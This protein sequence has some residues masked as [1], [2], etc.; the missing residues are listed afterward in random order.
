MNSEFPPIPLPQPRL[1]HR[2]RERSP[3]PKLEPA[4]IQIRREISDRLRQ[5]IE[6][7]DRAVRH[8]SPEQKR[9]IFLKLTHDRPLTKLDLQGTGLK[10]ISSPGE[11]ETLV[12][13]KAGDLGKLDKRIE[14]FG[15]N[16]NAEKVPKGQSLALKLINIAQ[17]KPIDRLS[18]ELVANYRKL[19]REP[20]LVYEIEISSF[21]SRESSQRADI[22]SILGEL[23]QFLGVADGRIYDVDFSGNGARLV[24]SSTGEKFRHLVELPQWQTKITFFDARPRFQTFSTV[25]ENFNI[26]RITIES[27]PADAPV[28]CVVDSGVAAGNP[29]LEKVTRRDLLRSYVDGCSGSSDEDGHGSGVASLA[30]Y[31]QID[32]SNGATNSAKAWIASAK[33]TNSKGE[34][35]TIEISDDGEYRLQQAYLLSSLLRRVVVDF[36]SR[37]VQIFVL[38][39]NIVGHIWSFAHRRIIARNAWVAR[40]ID[41]LCR[42]HD[43][44]FVTITGNLLAGD[45]ADLHQRQ[46][47]PRY[48]GAPLAKLQDPGQASLAVTVGSIAHS[49]RAVVSDAVAIALEGQPSPFT[50]SGPGLGFS[51]K[52]DFVERGGNVLKDRSSGRIINNMG[53]NVVM[54]SNKLSPALQ[55]S[56]GTS[57]AAPRVAHHLALILKEVQSL[58]IQPSAPLLRALL[59]CSSELPE[60]LADWINGQ[61]RNMD[62]VLNILGYGLP[63]GSDALNCFGHSVLLFYQG[64]IEAN[65]VAFFELPIPTELS[66]STG[67]KRIV[68]SAAISPPVQPWGTQEYLGANMK[69]RVFRGDM[70]PD[71]IEAMMMRDEDEPNLAGTAVN[72]ISSRLGI[73]RRSIGTLQRD[74]FVWSE[75]KPEFSHHSYTL[76]IALK[77]ASW[78]KGSDLEIP[79]GVVVKIEDTTAQFA[80]LYA[81]VEQRIRA[82]ARS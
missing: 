70:D 59:A 25:Y 69:F 58:G 76:A 45:I 27:P 36:K 67:K 64:R 63:S 46:Q 14:E 75:H 2:R 37:G 71:R 48:F 82:R 54:A 73:N 24:L 11:K 23:R 3:F 55:H 74:T 43:V 32:F 40:T 18:E 22:E 61:I 77:P 8:L 12:L 7:V 10:F 47:Y 41:Q 28:I 62:D 38:S 31:Y 78:C 33:I 9:A 72:D 20:F 39:F 80:Q 44:V 6:V 1:G 50:R 51:I 35:D 21:Q 57:F 34:L 17:G 66:D 19:I 65:R 68:V 29:F 26:D 56:N 42:E 16:K 49:A 5:Q 13:P 15:S 52:P 53:T 30:A 81:R 60:T 4:T 79:L